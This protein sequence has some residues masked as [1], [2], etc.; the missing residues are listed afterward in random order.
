MLFK[1]HLIFILIC[2]NK[3]FEIQD[4]ETHQPNECS[5]HLQTD[6]GIKTCQRQQCM[7]IKDPWRVIGSYLNGQTC[8]VQSLQ[9]F[10]TNYDQFLVFVEL[11]YAS[12]TFV[13]SIFPQNSAAQ[14]VLEVRA[15]LLS[16]NLH[17]RWKI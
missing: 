1:L 9:L 17:Y 13:E 10:F 6:Q 8:Y 12:H 5:V 16:A 2:V 14:N 7:N 15:S 3:S 11:Q 4:T